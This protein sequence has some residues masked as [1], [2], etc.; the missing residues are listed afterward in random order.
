VKLTTSYVKAYLNEAP[1]TRDL[2]RVKTLCH[3]GPELSEAV[4]RA[5]FPV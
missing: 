4:M 2:G 1:S 3:Q 5:A